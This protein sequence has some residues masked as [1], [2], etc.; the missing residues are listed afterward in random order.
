MQLLLQQAS[1]H[2]ELGRA[3]RAAGRFDASRWHYLQAA[4]Y[5]FQAATKSRGH[6]KA[7]RTEW[8]ES[9]FA[10]A[11]TSSTCAARPAPSPSSRWL[12]AG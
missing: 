11:L 1:H 3:A 10:A 7:K 9:L 6:L 12:S 8:A 5:L 4:E 2:T